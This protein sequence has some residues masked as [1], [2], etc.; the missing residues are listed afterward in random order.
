MFCEKNF[1]KRACERG[2]FAG[3]R[4]KKRETEGM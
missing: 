3:I 2:A 4:T 1:G